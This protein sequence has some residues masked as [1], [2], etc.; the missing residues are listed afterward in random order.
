MLSL[1]DPLWG[2]LKHA[3]G[4]ASDIPAELARLSSRKP[5][6]KDYWIDLGSSLC[7]QYEVDTASYAAFPHLVAAAK[8]AKGRVRYDAMF[9]AS[10]I[11]ACSYNGTRRT[12][13]PKLKRPFQKAIVLGRKVLAEMTLEAR[14]KLDD[15]IHFV[16]MIAAFDGHAQLTGCLWTVSSGFSCPDCDKDFAEPVVQLSPF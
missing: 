6:P 15:S 14:P 4:T 13:P 2:K 8:K 3:Y 16:A 11:L 1:D 5:L 7:H 12:M 10:G 9:L